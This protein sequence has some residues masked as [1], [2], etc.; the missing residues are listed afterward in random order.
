MKTNQGGFP[1]LSL[2][3]IVLFFTIVLYVCC[4]YVFN[5][6]GIAKFIYLELDRDIIEWCSTTIIMVFLIFIAI[7]HYYKSELKD[8]IAECEREKSNFNK[9][10]EKQYTEKETNLNNLISAKEQDIARREQIVLGFTNSLDKEKYCAELIADFKTILYDEVSDRLENQKFRAPRAAETVRLLRAEAAQSI[11]ELKEYKYNERIRIE[12][13]QN[14]AQQMK[15]LAMIEREEERRITSFVEERLKQKKP[16]CDIAELYADALSVAYEKIAEQL[17]DRV[18]PAFVTATLIKNELKKQIRN[19]TYESKLLKYRWDFL[20]SSFPD[21]KE[22]VSDD[23]SLM[24]MAEYASISEFNE[25]R[26]KARDYLSEDEYNNLTDVEKYQLALDRYK[27]RR[28]SNAWIAGVEYEMYC[29][30]YL[31]EQ[32]F[33]VVEHGIIMRKADLGRDII[34]YKDGDTYIIQCKRYSLRNTD[35][36]DK[37]VHENVICQLFGTTIEYKVTNPN[38]RLFA[39]ENKIIPVLYTTGR[40]SKM[41][42][43]F[44][45]HLKVKVERID[46]EDYPMIKCNINNGNKIYHLPFDQQYWNTKIEQSGECYAWTVQEAEEKGFRRARRWLGIDD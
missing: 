20:L 45:N 30:Y 18:R 29:S 33:T 38:N 9:Q 35:G 26:D 2:V 19:A 10:L 4:H 11:R 5:K 24:S 34:A 28:R 36:T 46:I 31:R 21:L 44:A 40:L 23:E 43:T 22:Y 7:I 3:P 17:I 14:E 42:E 27:E 12:A 1:F 41:A 39:N 13:I 15:S 8:T 25:Q 37:F 6:I 32:G 16:F